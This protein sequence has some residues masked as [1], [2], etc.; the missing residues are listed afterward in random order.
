[1]NW[2]LVSTL[3]GA[4]VAFGF[5]LM[6]QGFGAVVAHGGSPVTPDQY[7][8]RVYAIPALVWVGIQQSFSVAA[9]FGMLI[10]AAGGRFQRT[11]AFVAGMGWTGLSCLFLLFGILAA[12]APSGALLRYASLFPA[13]MVCAAHAVLCGRLFFW[14]EAPE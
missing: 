11:A 6:A 3:T 14:G 12:D 7:G 9:I 5:Y 13:L 2:R 1:M 10:I 8:E 4:W